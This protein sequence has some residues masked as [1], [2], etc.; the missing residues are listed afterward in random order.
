MFG[1]LSFQSFSLGSALRELP[2]CRANYVK[3]FLF[4]F[5]LIICAKCS[6][7][8]GFDTISCKIGSFIT[9]TEC[10]ERRKTISGGINYYF[11]P[12]TH[13]QY[14]YERNALCIET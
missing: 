1:G 4:I 10:V 3:L 11:Y 12:V 14:C 7:A 9:D 2:S 5:H 6:I 8:Q 13:E